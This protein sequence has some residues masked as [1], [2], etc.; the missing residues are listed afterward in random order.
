[1]MEPSKDS[2]KQNLLIRLLDAVKQVGFIVLSLMYGLH[3]MLVTFVFSVKFG[4]EGNQN[5]RLKVMRGLAFCV[6]HGSLSCSMD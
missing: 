5:W 6:V 2:E 1:M 4:L 3:S